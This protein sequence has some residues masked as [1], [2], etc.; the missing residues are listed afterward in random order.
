MLFTEL[1]REIIEEI[2]VHC[3]PIDVAHVAQTCSGLNSII[4]HAPDCTLWRELYLGQPLDDPRHTVSHLGSPRSRPIDWKMELQQIIRAGSVVSSAYSL[5]L[6]KPGE[7]H[8]ILETL[9]QIVCQTISRRSEEPFGE[10]SSNLLWVAAMFRGGFLDIIGEA[11]GPFIPQEDVQRISRLHT[12]YGVTH[13][14]AKPRNLVQSRA[15]VY[16]MRNYRPETVYGPF[17]ES[18]EVNW[19]HMQAIHHVM[20]MHLIALKEDEDFDF[21][22]YP[23]SLPYTQTVILNDQEPENDWAGVTGSWLVSFCFCDHRDLM[24]KQ[25]LWFYVNIYS[26]C[27]Y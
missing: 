23:M 17:L 1:P 24:G 26:N 25:L 7:L 4:C 14:D 12:Y 19:I 22:I 16:L 18:G 9:L 15:Y 10:V 20:S 21:V 6:L 11:Y 8:T 3:D 13:G 27:Q 2:L 5:I